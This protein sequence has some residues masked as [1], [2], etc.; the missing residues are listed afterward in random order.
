MDTTRSSKSAASCYDGFYCAYDSKNV[1][2]CCEKNTDVGDCGDLLNETLSSTERAAPNTTI[3]VTAIFTP[4]TTASDQS[5]VVRPDRTPPPSLPGATNGYTK[6]IDAERDIST[7]V[8]VGIGIGA[9]IGAAVLFALAAFC[10]IHRRRKARY[11]ALGDTDTNAG[12]KVLAEHPEPFPSPRSLSP[13]PEASEPMRGDTV[14]SPDRRSSDVVSPVP[15]QQYPDNLGIYGTP[16]A[17][18]ARHR[19]L[20]LTH[21]PSPR[22]RAHGETDTNLHL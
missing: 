15:L 14:V 8:R 17:L 1:A 11:K 9:F 4:L 21:L 12:D 22:T 10:F 5:V 20:E 2:F 19:S 16:A 13:A 6:N 18:A 7:A 3:P